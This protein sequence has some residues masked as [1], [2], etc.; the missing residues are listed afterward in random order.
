M[1]AGIMAAVGVMVLSGTGGAQ[2]YPITPVKF[3][4]VKVTD[5]FWGKRM[6][7]NRT[8]TLPANF[9]K[10]EETGRISNFAKAAGLME[11]KHE[12]IF[13]NDS[14]VFKVVEGAAYTLALKPDPELDKKLDELVALFAGAQEDD[15]YLYTARTIDPGHPAPGSGSERWAD[16]KNA[17]ELY[18]MGHM[19]EA[20][21]AHYEATGK[22]SFL[23]VAVKCADLIDRT[24]GPDKKH[25]AT[26]HPELELALVKLSRATGERRYLEL[27]KFFVDER[28]NSA[29]REL[30]GP[31]YFDHKP[32]LEADEAVGHAVRT[33]YFLCGVAD[34]AALTG[35]AA[36]ISAV[37]RIWENAV[38]KKLYLTGGIGARREG[39]AFGD[40]YELPNL[41]A[42]CE[43]C[44]AIA[45]ALWNHRMFLL[46]GDGKYMDVF[47]RTVYNGFLAGVSMEGDTFF[48]PNPLSSDGKFPFNHGALKR[49]PW[50][51]CSCCPTNVVRFIPSLPG[52]AYASEGDKV[53]VNLY[54]AG[55]AKIP[56][57]RG[58]VTVAQQGNYPWDGNITLTVTP[59]AAGEFELRLRVPGWALAHPVPGDLY[60]YLNGDCDPVTVAVNGAPEELRLDKG[61][62][63]LRRVWNAGDT[64]SLVLPMPVRRVLCHE[65]VVENR[66]HAALERGPLVYC[67]EW[68]DN[69]GRVL[70]LYLDDK[71]PLAAEARPDLLGGVTVITGAAHAL[72]RLEDG[73]VA[74]TAQPLT[75]IPYY[76]WAHRGEG[77]MAV[78][79]ARS[80]NHA[81][82]APPPTLASESRP[83]A[84]HTNPG[85]SLAALSDGTEPKDSNDHTIPRFTWWPRRGGTEWVEYRFPQ[86][87][88]VSGCAVYWFD[89]EASGGGCRTP[90]SWRLLYLDGEKWKP[91]GPLARHGVKKDRFN[92][93]GFPAV[94]TTGLRIEAKLKKDFSGGLLE[95]RLNEE[96]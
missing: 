45:N 15:G 27:A 3:T 18:N 93:C 57:P 39:E 19:M 82:P 9:Q 61:Y 13:F 68:L 73:T 83:A 95:W 77:E 26:G 91:I 58:A 23:D 59:E 87:A 76:A 41:M 40:N 35:N 79:L 70:D 12:G 85:D 14:D 38:L 55:E 56:T 4:A 53:Y 22:R 51:D 48:Y 75:A 67:A 5:A 81:S 63:V 44:A 89:D 50:F 62:A 43:T 72:K 2:D 37:D 96:K 16:I 33:A 30:Y 10:S 24:F 78:W 34:V 60:Y 8:V 65:N 17:H 54:M 25:A 32:L 28:G 88:V 11:G 64:V 29:H 92:E 47:E 42:Y 71:T 69:G 46:H 7:T 90:K 20:A 6:E 21:V 86:E 52:F 49:S 66:G 31:Y 74:D 94:R 1:R 80:A 84:S 36:Y